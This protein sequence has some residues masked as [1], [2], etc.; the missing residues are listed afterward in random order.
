MKATSLVAVPVI[1]VLL[2]LLAAFVAFT[3]I[4]P[5]PN[6]SDIS[7]GSG[8]GVVAVNSVGED[9][10]WH[11]VGYAITVDSMKYSCYV[12]VRNKMTHRVLGWSNHPNT[13]CS[14]VKSNEVLK[15]LN[16]G[17]MGDEFVKKVSEILQ[18]LLK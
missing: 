8:G 12:Q 9:L 1:L 6:L 3:A 16:L 18:L 7:F 2:L 4:M 5:K 15:N 10:E 14:Q 13:P 11:G 17:R